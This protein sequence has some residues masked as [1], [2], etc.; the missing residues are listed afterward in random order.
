MDRFPKLEEQHGEQGTRNS[1][2]KLTEAHRWLFIPE[3]MSKKRKLVRDEIDVYYIDAMH[4]FLN[5]ASA[6][7]WEMNLEIMDIRFI[8]PSDALLGRWRNRFQLTR[9][10]QDSSGTSIMLCSHQMHWTRT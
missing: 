8:A 2:C 5:R 7:N 6:V 4:G 3:T 1:L 10:F 9:T